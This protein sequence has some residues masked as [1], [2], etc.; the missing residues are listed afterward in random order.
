VNGK[1]ERMMKDVVVA[2]FKVIYFWFS[3]ESEIK[4][5]QPQSQHALSGP[6]TDPGIFRSAEEK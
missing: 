1:L 3:G 4:D 2:Y 6:N 5:E